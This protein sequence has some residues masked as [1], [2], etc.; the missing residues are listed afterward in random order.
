MKLSIQHLQ[1]RWDTMTSDEKEERFVNFS[2]NLVEQID[3]LS[4]IASEFSSFA[5]LKDAN[6]SEVNLMSLINS[7]V[8]VYNGTNDI[9]VSCDCD[10]DYSI[11]G[12][13][14][15]VLRVFNNLIKNAIQAIPNEREGWVKVAIIEEN[16]IILVSV[17][18]NGNG[19][20]QENQDKIFVPNFTTKN[21]GMGL[22]LAM[23]QKII[24]NMNGEITF[25]TTPEVGTKFILKF[26]LIK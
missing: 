18:D 19:I 23:V 21:S 16:D 25:K 2:K 1:M 9:K 12:D 3:T 14:D 15:Q 10:K 22:G 26:P 13:K 5:K 6:F 20:S 24:E 17:I 7:S 11:L 4:A 8:G